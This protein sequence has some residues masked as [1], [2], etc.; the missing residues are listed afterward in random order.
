MGIEPVI[1]MWRLAYLK[2]A[3][4][5]MQRGGLY[6]PPGMHPDMPKVLVRIAELE[7]A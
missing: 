1:R 2:W 6:H 7:A 4:A 5:D 3:L